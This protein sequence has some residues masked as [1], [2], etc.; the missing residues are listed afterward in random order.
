MKKIKYIL[1]IA[2]LGAVLFSCKDFL[3]EDPKSSYSMDDFKDTD[4]AQRFL[5]GVYKTLGSPNVTGVDARQFTVDLYKRS[6]WSQENGL[7]NYTFNSDNTVFRTMWAV[8]Y[9]VIKDCNVLID[10]INE[11]IDDVDDPEWFIAQARGVRGYLYFDLARWFGDVPLVLKSWEALDLAGMSV[12]RDPTTKVFKQIVEDFEYCVKYSMKK[13]DTGNGYQYGR[14]TAEAAHGFLAKVHLW[15]ASV[16]KRDNTTLFGDPAD[17]Y[18]RSLEHSRAVIASGSY[19]LTPYYPDM[20]TSSTKLAAQDE[21]LMCTEAVRGDATGTLTGMN[22]GITGETTKGGSWGGLISTDYHRSTYEPSDSI[23]K[24]WN[25][26][27]AQIQV[28]G[29]L[30]SWDYQKYWNPP[31]AVRDLHTVAEQ[32]HAMAFNIGKFRRFPIRDAATYGDYDG[33]DEPLLRYSDVLLM[34]GEAYNEVNHGPGAYGGIGVADFTGHPDMS[35]FDA[36]NIVRKRARVDN[37]GDVHEDLIP[38]NL[39]MSQIGQSGRTGC[40]PDWSPGFYGW[41]YAGTVSV[42]DLREYAS[43]YDAFLGELLYERGRELVAETSDRWCDLVR[44]GKLLSQIQLFRTYL[45]PVLG[46]YERDMDAPSAPENIKPYMM[47]LPIPLSALDA[48]RALV[49]NPNY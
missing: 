18:R 48:N 19:K 14:M 2:A 35:A 6:S 1:A 20:F 23:R 32:S 36:V 15:M 41:D 21:M 17:N 3:T 40:V 4:D 24:Y 38:R 29:Y 27:R 9:A 12:P 44:W 16:D 26:P 37:Y 39:D 43:D 31:G 10:Q 13:G 45:N 25:A 33:M 34:Y 30:Y 46:K 42:Y 28:N 11:H 49:Q 5:N 22:F 7:A 8:H 47:L